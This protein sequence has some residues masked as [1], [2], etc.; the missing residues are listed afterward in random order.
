MSLTT[1][2]FLGLIGWMLFMH[3][4]RGGQ[5]G[6]CGGHGDKDHTTQG[7]GEDGAA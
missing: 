6:C 3:M 5:G 1:L 4:R 7:G 2:I